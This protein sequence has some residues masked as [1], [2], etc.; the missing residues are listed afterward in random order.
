MPDSLSALEA[1]RTHIFRQISALGDLRPGSISAVVRRCGK[2]TC[3]CA[4][5]DDPG[6]HPQ[7]RLTRTVRGKTV[8][9]SFASPATFHK[10]QAEVRE[11]QR[12]QRLCA[13]LVE[14]SERICRLRPFPQQAEKWSAEEKKRL[15]RSIKKSRAS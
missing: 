13:E 1:Q 6:H 5:P 8:A 14:V 10:A 15:L 4:K 2:P 11:Y 9:E 7:L 3:H 12:W